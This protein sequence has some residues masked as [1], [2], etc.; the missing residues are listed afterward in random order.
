MKCLTVCARVPNIYV[1]TSIYTRIWWKNYTQAGKSVFLEISQKIQYCTMYN[2][3]TVPVYNCTYCTK[4][5]T[6]C[7]GFQS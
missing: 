3:H 2:V 5:S 6:I 7:F 1:A 4:Y